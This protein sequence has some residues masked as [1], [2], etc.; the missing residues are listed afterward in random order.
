LKYSLA[1]LSFSFLPFGIFSDFEK[2]IRRAK[3]AHAEASKPDHPKA[4]APEEP[5]GILCHPSP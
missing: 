1:L 4:K 2:D 5:E 3:S